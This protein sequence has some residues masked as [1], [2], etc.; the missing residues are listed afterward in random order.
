VEILLPNAPHLFVLSV[1]CRAI[2]ELHLATCEELG[3]EAAVRAEVEAL[4]CN[5]Q[6]LLIGISIMQVSSEVLLF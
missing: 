2:R 6:Q 3:V 5:L 4:L 1:C